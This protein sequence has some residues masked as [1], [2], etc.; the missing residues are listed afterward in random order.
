MMYF[1]THEFVATFCLRHLWWAIFFAG[2]P[3]SEGS[4][5][6]THLTRPCIRCLPCYKIFRTMSQNEELRTFWCKIIAGHT[7]PLA[8]H[9]SEKSMI[10]STQTMVHTRRRDSAPSNRERKIRDVCCEHVLPGYIWHT[11]RG[12]VLY[13]FDSILVSSHSFYSNSLF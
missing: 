11:W 8:R 6:G 2:S 10:L 13:C 7:H 3:E 12:R 1:R 4:G 5:N 9:L